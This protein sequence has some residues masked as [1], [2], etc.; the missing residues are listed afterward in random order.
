MLIST[1]TSLRRTNDHTS[2]MTPSATI[3]MNSFGIGVATVPGVDPSPSMPRTGDQFMSDVMPCSKRMPS[4]KAQTAA[5]AKPTPHAR[6]K[7]LAPLR[8]NNSGRD[9]TT[10]TMVVTTCEKAVSA[11]TMPARGV[12]PRPSLVSFATKPRYTNENAKDHPNENSPARVDLMLPPKIEKL[13]M[14][15]YVAPNAA[16]SPA[17]TRAKPRQRMK[18]YTAAGR[19]SKPMIVV[20]LK[21]TP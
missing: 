6:N 4:G 8:R 5:T 12:K 3:G 21:A 7:V 1:R 15:T 2:P 9:T 13:S 19:A 17:T 20:S 10:T 16:A 18:T 14:K 11:R